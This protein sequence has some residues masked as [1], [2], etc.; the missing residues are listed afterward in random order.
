MDLQEKVINNLSELGDC[1]CGTL[2]YNEKE[3][4]EILCVH[5]PDGQSIYFLNDLTAATILAEKRA[6][7]LSILEKVPAVF[8]TSGSSHFN[9]CMMKAAKERGKKVLWDVGFYDLSEEYVKGAIQFVDKIFCN[10]VELHQICKI[11]NTTL[12]ELRNRC[13]VI[14]H[15]K[16]LGECV[17]YGESDYTFGPV[18]IPRKVSPIGCC[19]AFSASFTSYW[20]QRKSVKECAYAG[21]IAS[22]N[23][24]GYPDVQSGM[25]RR[26][27]L[28]REILSYI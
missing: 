24:W 22:K 25:V 13:E 19:D 23:V 18:S 2:I 16:R 27:E 10:P 26:E 20:L 7:P 17:V 28:E 3:I 15:D 9:L 21:L 4:A 1:E 5:D 6:I 12:N 8:I 14:V 11:A